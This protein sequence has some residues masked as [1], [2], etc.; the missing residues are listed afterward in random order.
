MPARFGK[1]EALIL[2]RILHVVC[3]L[4][5]LG[6][7]FLAQLGWIYFAGISFVSLFLIRENWL[8]HRYGLEKVDQ[9]FF[10]MNAVVSLSIF[11]VV[12]FDIL[13]S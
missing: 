3:L 11:L 4:S 5:W 10:T 12:I 8:I 9:A 2:V 7:G 13:I 1:K 6:A